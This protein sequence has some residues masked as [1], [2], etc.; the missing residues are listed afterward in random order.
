[1]GLLDIITGKRKIP[2][3]A[4]DRLFA[5]STAYVMLETELDITS[6]GAAAIVFQPLQTADFAAI[7]LDMEEVVRA[8]SADS[9]TTVDTSHDSYGFRWLTL[10]GEDFEQLVAGINAVS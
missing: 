5:M 2:G 1:M 7:V 9:G 4:P 6:R 8:T 3:P 10:R